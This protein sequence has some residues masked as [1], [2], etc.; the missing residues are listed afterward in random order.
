MFFYLGTKEYCHRDNIEG[1][2][3]NFISV[4][5]ACAKRNFKFAPYTLIFQ[6]VLHQLPKGSFLNYV[7]KR[8]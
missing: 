5:G 3:T 6:E 2:L 8:G 4:L 1:W 7:D